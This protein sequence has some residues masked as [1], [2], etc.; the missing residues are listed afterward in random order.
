MIMSKTKITAVLALVASAF[1][2]ACGDSSGPGS[3]DANAAVQSLAIA[4][5][6]GGAAQGS[7]TTPDISTTLSAIAPLLTRTSVTVGGV[8][9]PMFAIGIRESFPPGTC[10]ENLYVDP[11]FPPEPGVCT[12]PSLNTALIFWQSHSA[13]EPPD[14]M[15]FVVTDQGSVDFDYTDPALDVTPAIGFYVEGVDN[16]LVSVSGNVTSNVASLNQPCSITLPP[17]AKAAT[18]NFASFDEQA[19]MRFEPFDFTGQGTATQTT[20]SI[21]RQTL[22]GLW[23]AI[24][25]TQPVTIPILANR[26]GGGLAARIARIA[27]AFIRKR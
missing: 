1:L 2:S 21:P 19:Q 24:T 4:L 26:V 6:D 8:S 7:L 5:Q 27:P 12:T 16:F 14:R 25:Q 20:I 10:E 23:V 9:Q 3:I 13:N 18:C 11:D 17:Y 22:P 15:L